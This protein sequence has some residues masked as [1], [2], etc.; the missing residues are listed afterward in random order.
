VKRGKGGDSV[1]AIKAVWM[2][3]Y[4]AGWREGLL[5]AS[6]PDACEHGVRLKNHCAQCATMVVAR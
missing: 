2:E 1:D 5:M 6:H 3:G 4:R